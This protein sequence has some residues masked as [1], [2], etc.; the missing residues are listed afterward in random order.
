MWSLK[1]VF[2]S[3]AEI[4]CAEKYTMHQNIYTNC[5]KKTGLSILETNRAVKK[6]SLLFSLGLI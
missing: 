4:K 2:P 6:I 3:D 5:V 1:A